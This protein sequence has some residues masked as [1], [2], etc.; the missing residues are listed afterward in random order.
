MEKELAKQIAVAKWLSNLGESQPME[1]VVLKQQHTFQNT[2][3][4]HTQ[5]LTGDL[6]M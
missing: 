6:L 5:N 3:V 1:T 2:K 4:A